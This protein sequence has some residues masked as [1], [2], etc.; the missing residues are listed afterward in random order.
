MGIA[1]AEG[2]IWVKFGSERYVTGGDNSA[3]VF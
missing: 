1:L 2:A 3:M